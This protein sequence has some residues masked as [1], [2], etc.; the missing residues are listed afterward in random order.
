MSYLKVRVCGS[1][2][3]TGKWSLRLKD[4]RHFSFLEGLT[5]ETLTTLRGIFSPR[6]PATEVFAIPASSAELNHMLGEVL[7][8]C[9]RAVLQGRENK[10]SDTH[11]LEGR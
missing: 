1:D 9:G 8:H 11:I 6:N 4:T 7:C 10:S 5:L 3:I 2:Q